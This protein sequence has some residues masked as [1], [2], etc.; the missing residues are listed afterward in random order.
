MAPGVRVFG[1]AVKA[2][3]KSVATAKQPANLLYLC[4]EIERKLG[5]NEDAIKTLTAVLADKDLTDGIR[6]W[7]KDAIKKAKVAR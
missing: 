4:G 5:R 1:E 3:R 6:T 2:Q 7:A